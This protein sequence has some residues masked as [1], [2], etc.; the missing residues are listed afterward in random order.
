VWINGGTNT[1]ILAHEFGHT[2]GLYHSHAL[3]CHP[4]VVTRRAPSSSTAMAPTPWAAGTA[5]TTPSRSSARVA[6]LQRVPPITTVSSERCL[7]HRRL[8]NVR[9]GPKSAEDRARDD[10]AVVLRRAPAQRGVGHQSVPDRGL[11]PPGHRQ[12]SPTAAASST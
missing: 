8:R 5:T 1:G 2:L 3:N 12:I 6:R 10:R 4:A 9:H 11:H 7:H